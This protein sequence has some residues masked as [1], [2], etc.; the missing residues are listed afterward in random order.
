MLSFALGA[1]S[2]GLHTSVEKVFYDSNSCSCEFTLS[3]EAYY[4]S[5]TESRLR[6]I[7]L[8]SISQFE[9]FGTICHG[10]FV[11]EVEDIP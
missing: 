1:A 9:W 3:R 4:G 6:T 8:R 11:P 10:D 5:Q 7:A 2:E